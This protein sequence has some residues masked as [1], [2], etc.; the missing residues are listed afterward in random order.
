VRNQVSRVFARLAREFPPE[1]VPCPV[2]SDRA[3]DQGRIAAK[4]DY[5]RGHGVALFPQDGSGLVRPEQILVRSAAVEDSVPDVV[6]ARRL[7]A[8]DMKR[9]QLLAELFNSAQV[10]V[11]VA[12]TSGKSTT[13]ALL[14]HRQLR[15]ERP[16]EDQ[17]RWRQAQRR[18][19]PAL[20]YATG[21]RDAHRHITLLLDRLEASRQRVDG[22]G[23]VRA[24]LGEGHAP[25]QGECCRS[26][27]DHGAHGSLPGRKERHRVIG[28]ACN[29]RGSAR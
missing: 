13:T 27:A 24:V 21:Q 20:V 28:S 9:P 16:C 19:H 29:A 23:E 11:G 22:D 4:F 2:G 10:R 18:H 3:L 25:E 15:F 14:H 7:G 6:A 1:R 5:L 8:R 12:G 17:H 26:E